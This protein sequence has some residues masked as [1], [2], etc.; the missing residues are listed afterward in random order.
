ML[1]IIK[2]YLQEN[3]WQFTQVKDK[4]IFLFGIAGKNGN[5]QCI[6]DIVED[7]HKFIFFSVYGANVPPE[8]RPQLLE[9]IN[10]LNVNFF[11]GNF[12]MDYQDGEIRYR[13]GVYLEFIIPNKNMIDQLI[14]TNIITMDKY[15]PALT[16]VMFGGLSTLQAIDLVDK[17]EAINFEIE[18]LPSPKI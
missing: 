18:K 11:V 17:S 7:E 5:F 6:A 12:E 10:Y 13:T 3:D 1:K 4:D 8:K 2:E 14:M 15:L 9:L 16:G